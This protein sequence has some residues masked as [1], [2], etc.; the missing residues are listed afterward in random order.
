[1]SACHTTAHHHHHHLCLP[2]LFHHH[3]TLPHRLGWVH[4]PATWIWISPLPAACLPP[5]ANTCHRTTT[6]WVYLLLHLPGFTTTLPAHL[7]APR[8]HRTPPA[9]CYTHCTPDSIRTASYRDGHS[10]A[11]PGPRAGGC[12]RTPP[13]HCTCPHH[14]PFST[15]PL[16]HCLPAP[17]HT[18]HHL[19][20]HTSYHPA[21]HHHHVFPIGRATTCRQ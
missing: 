3:Y 6:T 13:P 10:T 14:P 18:Y 12:H 16:H 8:L 4:L 7:P 17:A 9:T 15:P 5:A 19:G 20:H 11:I 1:M 21:H 2:N